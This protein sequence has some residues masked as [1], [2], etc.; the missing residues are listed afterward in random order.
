MIP[1]E[2]TNKVNNIFCSAALADKQTGTMY[3][4]ATCAL[5]VLSLEGMQYF[6]VAYDYDTNYIFVVPI[7]NLKDDTIVTAFDGVFQE[8]KKKE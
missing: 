4:D 6:F 7:A 2:E 5:P 1:P 3:T 8:L